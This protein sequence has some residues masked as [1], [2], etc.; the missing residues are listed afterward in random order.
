LSY[1][2]LLIHQWQTATT[3]CCK[4]SVNTVI[5]THTVISCALPAYKSSSAVADDHS[6]R[7]ASRQMAKF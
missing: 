5:S 1:R 3:H 4:R 2:R 6:R 7:A